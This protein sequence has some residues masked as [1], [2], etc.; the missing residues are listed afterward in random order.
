MN[1]AT[2]DKSGTGG[3]ADNLLDAANSAGNDQGGKGDTDKKSGAAKPTL[4]FGYDE[5]ALDSVFGK[6]G[7]DGRPANL[8]EK[9]WNKEGKSVKADVLFNQLRW[10]EGKI[11][12]P[13]AIL[14]APAEGSDYELKLPAE[15]DGLVEIDGQDPRVQA[16]VEVARKHDLSQGFVS[17]IIELAASKVKTI[18]ESTL[19]QEIG[20]LGDNSSERLQNMSDFLTANLNHEQAGIVK[21]LLE[22]A[23]IFEAIETLIAKAAPPKFADKDGQAASVDQRQALKDD[24]ERKYFEKDA[25]GERRMATDPAFAKEVNA[26]RDLVFGTTRRDAQGRAVAA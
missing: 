20:K 12:K 3:D 26:L 11:G 2:K 7:E 13:L 17:E 1:D 19:K 23:A 6:P 22:S 14:G 9:Y 15:Y 4:A 18:T 16:L 21:G 10:A 8:P 24:W 25:N 5:K